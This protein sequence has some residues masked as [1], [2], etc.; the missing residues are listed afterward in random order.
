MVLLLLFLR[1]AA[2]L[3]PVDGVGPLAVAARGGGHA[4]GRGGGRAVI[5]ALGGI[6]AAAGTLATQGPLDG[7]DVAYLLAYP[8]GFKDDGNAYV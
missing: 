8:Y 2:P 3:G 1:I 7:H 4:R 6:P 5:G